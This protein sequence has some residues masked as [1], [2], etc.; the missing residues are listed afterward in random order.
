M[1]RRN[2]NFII[3]DSSVPMKVNIKV[4]LKGKQFGSSVSD[5]S[6]A[7]WSR[8][9]KRPPDRGDTCTETLKYKTAGRF[10]DPRSEGR[11]ETERRQS[12]GDRKSFLVHLDQGFAWR[13]PDLG[14]V[15]ALLPTAMTPECLGDDLWETTQ[16]PD[17]RV[18]QC[19][20]RRANIALDVFWGCQCLVRKMGE[21]GR[22][23]EQL[24]SLTLK[25]HIV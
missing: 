16:P 18:M 22:R 7:R 24:D 21:G 2:A 6:Q 19:L 23:G 13:V 25:I 20:S 5:R 10:L 14:W 8:W 17:V 3:P 4:S 11:A 12:T 1:M 9:E 15:E